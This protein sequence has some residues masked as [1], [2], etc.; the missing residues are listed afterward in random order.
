MIEIHDLVKRYGAQTAVD[1]L[2]LTIEAGQVCGLLGLNG[3]GKTTTMNM[4][5][6]YLAPTEGQ[7]IVNGHDI[8]EEAEEAKRCIG[9]LPDQP[10][11]YTDMTVSEYLN[12]CAQLKQLP[13]AEQAT[14]IQKA[15]ELTGLQEIS[16][17]LIR[18]LSKGYRQ[19]VGLAQAI[20]GLPEIIILDEPTDG[21]DPRQINEMLALIRTLGE[22]HTVILSSHKLSEVQM[23]CD[24]IVILHQG[25]VIADGQPEELEQQLNAAA[26]LTLTALADRAQVESVLAGID[27]IGNVTLSGEDGQVTAQLE[28][29]SGR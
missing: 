20:L 29:C 28:S 9:Y 23:A 2:N 11:L 17:R 5:T 8:L 25:R 19:R 27:G 7:I 1:H 21:L 14:H 12:F 16:G 4:I 3:A 24:R 15:V 22:E 10:P 13:K 26:T 18:N 6:G